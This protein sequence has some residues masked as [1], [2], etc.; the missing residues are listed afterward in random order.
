MK[1]AVKTAACLKTPVAQEPRE[2]RVNSWPRRPHQ[3]LLHGRLGAHGRLLQLSLGSRTKGAV[4][5]MSSGSPAFS[6]GASGRDAGAGRPYFGWNE[7]CR[8]RGARKRLTKRAR[9][10]V[11]QIGAPRQRPH[12]GWD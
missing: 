12:E 2:F 7:E 1:P 11:A 8:F 6:V 10:S 3:D 4:I 5:R 9:F